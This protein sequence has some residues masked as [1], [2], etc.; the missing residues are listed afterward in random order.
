MLRMIVAI[1]GLATVSAVP[2]QAEALRYPVSG[3]PAFTLAVPPGWTHKPMLDN[4]QLQTLVLTS[5]HH[6]E[7]AT[8][9]LPSAATPEEFATQI[10][11]FSHLEMKNGGPTVVSGMPGFMFDSS[12]TDMTGTLTNMHVVQAKVDKTH[13]ALIEIRSPSKGANARELVEGKQIVAS[14]K[15]VGTP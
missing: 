14:M 15:L 3:S 13:I 1:A 7:V 12:F 5:A 9:I 10:S 4:G 2:A 6:V 8:L 11:T